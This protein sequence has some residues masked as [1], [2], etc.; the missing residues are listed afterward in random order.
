MSEAHKNSTIT[1]PNSHNVRLSYSPGM[2]GDILAAHPQLLRPLTSIQS[3][4]SDLFD[5]GLN[6]FP[7]PRPGEIRAK[8]AK[9]TNN[10]DPNNKRPYILKPLFSSR[11]HKCSDEC[12]EKHGVP[13]S[14]CLPENEMFET[15]FLKANIAVM[16]GRTSGNLFAIDCDSQD[17]F[18]K[19]QTRHP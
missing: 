3:A 4:A 11:M 19:I 16:L 7:I 8:A 9:T 1:T 5:R 14:G 2:L 18:N 17:S 10:L 12:R 13:R 6:V 15:L